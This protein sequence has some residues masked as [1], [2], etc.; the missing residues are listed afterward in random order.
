MDTTKTDF[1]TIHKV[2]LSEV[3]P[4]EENKKIYSPS[5]E[6]RAIKL[7]NDIKRNGQLEPLL[8]TLDGVI[9]SGHT[10]Y[11]AMQLLGRKFV[12]V[13]YHSIYSDDP[14]FVKL[15]VAANNQRVKSN[16][17]LLNEISVTIDPEAYTKRQR[18]QK[19]NLENGV[20]LKRV[21]G[22]LKSS[23]RMTG[24]YSEAVAAIKKLLID[25]EEYRPLT[26][27]S[28]HYQ[29]LNDPPIISKRHGV[30]RRFQNNRKDYNTLSRITTK[31]R[32]N[33]V[34]P[35][36]W[37][38]DKTRKYEP[39]RGFLSMYEFLEQEYQT[40]LAGYSR[41]FMQDQDKH[42]VIVCEKETVSSL[43]NLVIEKY[44]VPVIY[45]KGGA[46]ADVRYRL[47]VDWHRNG[48][49]PICLLVLSD[50]DPAGYRIQDSFVGSIKEDFADWLDGT[51]VYAYRAG[52]TLDHVKKYNLHTSMYAKKTDTNYREFVE[53]TGSTEAY[54]LDALPPDMFVD[55]LTKA[56]EQVI[57]V[58]K[59]NDQIAAFN[60]EA[61]ELERLRELT[62]SVLRDVQK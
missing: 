51:P 55:E 31:M 34:I 10:R 12:K 45:T 14:D 61:T 18:L 29:L 62:L 43:I 50:L 35:F 40:L 13:R 48:K 58:K 3:R 57:D 41:D 7:A 6:D 42:V 16:Q 46:S 15:L 38:E 47:L 33:G 19:M 5:H 9:I 59:V 37:I 20:D 24:Y 56:L 36:N 1:D 53:A 44:P 60:P 30:P 21:E 52:I 25:F 49:K 8:V 26:V 27:R 4:S 28:I 11:Q 54:E 39:N 17:E 2:R 23:R 32:I 22:A